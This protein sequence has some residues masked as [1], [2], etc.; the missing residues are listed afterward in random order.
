[1]NRK[2]QS[3]FEEKQFDN[4]A[5]ANDVKN[6]CEARLT[7]S[8]IALIIAGISTLFLVCLHN[9]DAFFAL[10]LLGA[11]ASYIVGGGFR[12]MVRWAFNI[13]KFGWLVVP[14]PLDLC[15]GLLCMAFSLIAF[16]FVP[17]VFVFLNYIQIRKDY[18]AAVTYLGYFR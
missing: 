14:F 5:F 9:I 15:T 2:G 11:I 4:M 7:R 6:Q 16:M 10:G 1:M 8:K 3:L 17:V 12:H 13:A 18:N